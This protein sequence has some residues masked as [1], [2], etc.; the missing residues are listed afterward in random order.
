MNRTCK[1]YEM[2]LMHKASGEVDYIK[3]KDALEQHLKGCSVCQ[4][5]LKGFIEVDT[6]AAA[7]R[8]PSKQFQEKMA[9]LRQRAQKG[10]PPLQ[11]GQKIDVK[12]EIDSAAGKIYNCLKANGPAMP[13]PL[14]REK[15]ELFNYPFYEAMGWLAG[16]EKITFTKDKNGKPD[17]ASLNPGA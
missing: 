12:W 11:P 15:T 13:I 8:Q 6:F 2:D 3:D 16:Q 1:D 4:K 9:D 10:T 7:T 5:A 17:Y 14:I